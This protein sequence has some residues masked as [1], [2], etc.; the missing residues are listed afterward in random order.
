MTHNRRTTE[1]LRAWGAA[2]RRLPPD[3]DTRRATILQHAPSAPH[4]RAAIVRPRV[5]WFALAFAG[6]AVIA[7][8]AQPE[9]W[10][11]EGQF[12]SEITRP[13]DAARQEAPSPTPPS[14]ASGGSGAAHIESGFGFSTATGLSTR[15]I[16][17]VPILGWFAPKSVPFTDTRELLE[18]DYAAQLRVRH[19]AETSG[20]VQTIV[21]GHRGRV[22][23]ETT[24]EEFASVTFAIPATELERFRDEIRVLAGARFFTE[25]TASVNRLTDQVNYERMESTAA[26]TIAQIE[27]DRTDRIAAFR[28]VEAQYLARVRTLR[29]RTQQLREQLRTAID[30]DAR[31]ATEAQIR[32]TE[33]ETASAHAAFQPKRTAH[34]REIQSIDARLFWQN[35][36]LES[37][38]T[39]QVNLAERVATVTGTV[40]MERISLVG[41]GWAYLGDHWIAALLGVLAL[42]ALARMDRRPLIAPQ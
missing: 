41:V 24:S 1:H 10:F 19:V 29:D 38:Q 2:A 37:A 6:L 21:R 28:T 33:R 39:A 16:R 36:Q 42:L 3:A 11:A 40:A 23:A 30:A 18:T 17:D 35:E 34:D 4:A 22:D 14:T 8:I 25:R 9:R 15:D 31:N 27:R 12:V 26:E 7:I 32:D 13:N 5:P 20:R